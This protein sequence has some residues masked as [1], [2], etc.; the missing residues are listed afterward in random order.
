MPSRAIGKKRSVAQT[1]SGADLLV[2]SRPPGRLVGR[3]TQRRRLS[4]A[5]L[6]RAVG[7]RMRKYLRRCVLKAEPRAELNRS[8][9]ARSE[10][11]ADSG[12][13]LPKSKC[14]LGLHG[15]Q[16]VIDP[17]QVRHVEHVEKFP[18]HVELVAFAV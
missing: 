6:T 12:R 18:E 10:L 9:P 4:A 14:L 5:R 2:R 8:R 3:R 7:E 13:R 16:R 15:V 11:L 1:A 17:R